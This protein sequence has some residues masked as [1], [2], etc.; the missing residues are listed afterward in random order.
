GIGYKPLGSL[1]VALVYKY[2]KVEN[3]STSVSGANANGSYA[4]GGATGTGEGK[5][6]EIGVYLRWAF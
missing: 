5:F 1:D 3:G 6:N 4:I 2:E